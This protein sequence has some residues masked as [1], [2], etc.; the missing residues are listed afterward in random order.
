MTKSTFFSN[1]IRLVIAWGKVR[2]NF[3]KIL[4]YICN[5]AL[6]KHSNK[7][8]GMSKQNLKYVQEFS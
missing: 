5:A 7:L 1:A 2:F 8:N 3:L 6:K 4:Y